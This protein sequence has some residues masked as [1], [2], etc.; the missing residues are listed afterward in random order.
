M[1]TLFFELGLVIISAAIIGVI[2]YYL[3]QPLIL[4][5]IA[6]GVLIGPFGFGLIQ[7]IE[8]I[9]VIAN[10]GIMLMLFLVG[11][12]MNPKRLKGLGSVAFFTGLGQVLV[13]GIIGYFLLSIFGFSLI[14]TVYLTIALTFSSTVIAVKMIYDKG[15]NNALYGQ[16]AISVLLVQDVIAILALLALSGFQAGSFD[17]DLA[18]FG[19]ILAEGIGLAIF[20]VLVAGKI[21]GYIYRK[22]A[23]SNELLILFSLGWAFLVA[24]AAE[25]IGFNIEIGA[26]I[27]GI[28][29]ASLPYTFEIN[30]KAKVLRDFFI[31]I[32]FVGL[33]AGIVFASITP[34][35]GKLVVLSLFVVIGNPIIV[36]VIMGLLGYDRRSSFFTGLSIANISEFSLIVVAMGLGLGHL[37]QATVSMVAII[38][39]L[40][41]T[42]SSYFMTYNNRIYNRLS[43]ILKIFEFRNVKTKLSTKKFGMKNHVILLGCGQMGQQILDQLKTFKEDYLVVDHDN[44]VIKNLIEKGI[45]CIF[46]DIEDSE[47]IHELDLEE[48]EIIISTL[49]GREGNLFLIKRLGLMPPEKRPIVI[50]VANSGREGFELFNA[51]ADYVIL[52]PYLG[53]EHIHDINRKLYDLPEEPSTPIAAELAEDE[54]TKFKSDFQYAKLLHNLNK[55]R[56]AEIKQKIRKRHIVL[57]AKNG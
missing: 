28:S 42:I 5:Y 24:L 19:V 20:A 11:L 12:E 21:L 4:A 7:D 49:P 44:A 34:F 51:G 1:E 9:N 46:G 50:T 27:A 40:T 43:G 41:M 18:G 56:L 38:A 45:T 30:A 47:L 39:V 15:D 35:I 14:E 17:F 36:M 8:T 3:K 32:F 16:V 57:K 25:Y 54:K 26:F 48:A 29:L 52:K 53:A 55:L 10:V 37:D 22:I 2:S 31:T 33:G 6:A 23:T 13:T